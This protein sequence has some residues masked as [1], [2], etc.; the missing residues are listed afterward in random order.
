MPALT[1]QLA[2]DE[3][4]LREAVRDKAE[5]LLSSAPFDFPAANVNSRRRYVRDNDVWRDLTSIL[6]PD[7]TTPA[8][9]EGEPDN[10][11]RTM[12]LVTV[13]TAASDYNQRTRIWNLTFAVKV[14]YGFKDERP[15]S[16]GNSYDELMKVVYTLL[17]NLVE[18]STLGFSDDVEVYRARH[19]GTRFV[20]S[21]PQGRPAH[22]ADCEVF[23]T[24]EV[25]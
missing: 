12:R 4:L 11:A 21:D 7:D 20:P 22:V 5:A 13:E 9:A 14:G 17:Q 6:D 3:K 23:A 15:E 10:R 16:R 2:D 1:G 18:D 24:V 8:P 25:C 19:A